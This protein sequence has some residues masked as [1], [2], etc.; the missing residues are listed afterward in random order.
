M[1][2]T[3]ETKGAPIQAEQLLRPRRMSDKAADLWTT[4]NVVQ[5]NVV[6]GGV[7]GR[8][9]RNQ[10]TSTREITGIDQNVKINKALWML[11]DGMAKL[12]AAK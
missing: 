4:F 5:E 9:A 8:T 11:A 7:P 3:T 6:K 1:L 10:R 2:T 12:K